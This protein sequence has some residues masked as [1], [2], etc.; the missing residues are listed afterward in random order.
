MHITLEQWRLIWVSFTVGCL[1]VKLPGIHRVN[2]PWTLYYY[3]IYY[4]KTIHVWVDDA[5]QICIVEG[6]AETPFPSVTLPNLN[7]PLSEHSKQ[8]AWIMSQDNKSSSY[9][10]RR[11][12]YRG[13]GTWIK[14]ARKN[15]IILTQKHMKVIPDI[16]IY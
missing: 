12:H 13:L 14:I 10:Q 7:S 15:N 4:W 2:Q 6:W 16:T 3:G 8:A 11:N 5:V 1:Y 9:S